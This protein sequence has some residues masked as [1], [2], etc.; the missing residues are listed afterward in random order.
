M[1]DTT[2]MKRAIKIMLKM[3]CIKFC[4]ADTELWLPCCLAKPDF[5][6]LKKLKKLKHLSH[7]YVCVPLFKTTLNFLL[8]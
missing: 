4:S 5:K 8:G 1:S 7:V 6:N 2:E 3:D